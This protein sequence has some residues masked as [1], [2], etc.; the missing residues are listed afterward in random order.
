M[1]LG[2]LF[3]PLPPTTHPET[4][5]PPLITVAPALAPRQRRHGGAGATAGTAAAGAE[6]CAGIPPRR[7]GCRTAAAGA[8]AR[9]ITA[10]PATPLPPDT[11]MRRS[12]PLLPVLVPLGA[13]AYRNTLAA[14]ATAGAGKP[15]WPSPPLLPA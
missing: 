10:E 3:A 1:A 15:P 6:Y 5:V 11:L 7:F 9:R 12:R 14:A 13:C 4:V 2:S 8:E